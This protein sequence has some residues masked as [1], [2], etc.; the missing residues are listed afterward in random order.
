MT[1]RVRLYDVLVV[2]VVQVDLSS[3][4]VGDVLDGDVVLTLTQFLFLNCRQKSYTHLV[5]GADTDIV[6]LLQSLFAR[7]TAT[8]SC[9]SLYHQI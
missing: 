8:M 2:R 7:H 3:W 9:T 6:K 1:I 4:V 5:S